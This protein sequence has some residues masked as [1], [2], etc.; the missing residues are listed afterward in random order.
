MNTPAISRA[1]SATPGTLK[2]PPLSGAGRY[3][4]TC[5]SLMGSEPGKVNARTTF[6]LIDPS[7]A[8]LGR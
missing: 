7:G 8:K 6:T 4:L 3:V 2:R 5:G 1:M